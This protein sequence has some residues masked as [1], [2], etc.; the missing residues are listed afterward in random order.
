MPC[1]RSIIFYQNSP[2]TK[3][4]LKKKCKIFKRWGLCPQTPNSLRRLGAPPPDP[5][6][7]PLNCEFLASRLPHF[8]LFIIMWVFRSFCF[9]Q[10]FLHCS[11]ANLLM[12]TIINVCLML[13]CFLFFTHCMT[14]I[15]SCYI[16]LSYLFA[17]A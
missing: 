14:L 9:E 16:A 17:K 5:R 8:A 6:N 15:P 12:L 10:I 7:S 3:L 11:V 4:F 13:N 1:F 2:K